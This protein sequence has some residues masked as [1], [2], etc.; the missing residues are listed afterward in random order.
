[1]KVFEDKRL[2]AYEGRRTLIAVL[3]AAIYAAGTNLF[4]V[5]SGLYSSGVMGLC[6]ILRTLLVEYLH[7][8]FGSVDIAGMIYYIINIPIFVVGYKKMGKKFLLK[9][10]ICVTVM[11]A[12][13]AVI[14]VTQIVEDTM[15]A[16]VIGGIIC[17]AG[18][19]ILLR[20]GASGGGMDIVGVILVK[21]RQD[22]SVGRVNLAM[23]LVLYSA[24]LFLFDVETALYSVINAAVYSVAIDKLHSQNINVEVNVITKIS[25]QELEKEVFSE[26]GRG[27]TKWKTVGAY[28]HEESH[29]LYIMMSK[30]EVHQL[31]NIVHKYDPQ[32]FIVINEGVHVEGNYLKKL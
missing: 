32:A 29:I 14:P 8:S 5:P 22:F 9:T 17:G 1:M 21:W 2:L 27:I 7:L 16:C 13:M 24:C 23:N 11:S 15:L 4:I 25:S 28:T 26:L 3:G 12:G 10:L 19:G 20:M 30:Y 31:R 6:Q 18:V